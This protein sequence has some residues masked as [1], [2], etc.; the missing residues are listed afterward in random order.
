[1]T[2]EAEQRVL[3]Q[4]AAQIS[5]EDPVL[6]VALLLL[7]EPRGHTIDRREGE[8]TARGRTRGVVDDAAHDQ[9]GR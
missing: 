2:E 9:P 7:R 1:V 3:E 8:A 5:Q 6:A 4:L